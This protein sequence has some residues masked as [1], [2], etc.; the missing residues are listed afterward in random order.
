LEV[1]FK[2]KTVTRVIMKLPNTDRIINGKCSPSGSLFICCVDATR[3]GRPGR[4]YRM[5]LI[6][7]EF[8]LTYVLRRF[9]VEEYFQIPNGSAW[10]AD[11]DLFVIDSA[12]NTINRYK[13]FGL[14]GDDAYDF[15]SG[16]SLYVSK[17]SSI[18]VISQVLASRNYHIEGLTMDA[19]KMLWVTIAGA[20]CVLRVDPNTGQEIQRLFIPADNPCGC[21]FGKQLIA[22]I[23]GAF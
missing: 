13:V 8:H 17:I 4:L 5:K 16:G 3:T 21:V 11:D 18:K 14:D 6:N 1:D 9:L 2:S 20:G 10:V 7:N 15:F 12:F 22:A 23:C 19:D